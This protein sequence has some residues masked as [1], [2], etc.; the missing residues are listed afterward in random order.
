MAWGSLLRNTAVAA[1]RHALLNWAA[2]LAFYFLFAFFPTVLLV[3]ALLSALH[4]PG[5]THQLLPEFERHLPREAAALVNQ[6]LQR[7]LQEH[8]PGLVS[9]GIVLLLYASSQGF[10]GLMAALNI[11]YDVPETRPYWKQMMISYGLAFSAGLLVV[12]ALGLVLLGR[13]ILGSFAVQSHVG[14]V[15]EM[16]SPVIRWT[17]TLIFLAIAVRLLYRYAPNAKSDARG[18]PLAVATA[19]G[20]WVVASALLGFYI[21]RFSNYAAVYG[22][23]GAVIALMLWFYVLAL[24]LLLGA[25]LHN[26][27]LRQRGLRRE[28]RDAAPASGAARTRL[29]GS[30]SLPGE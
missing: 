4:L 10:A 20:L 25:E 2:A 13:H 8:V 5:L 27:W 21:N 24:A 19:L 11:A 30:K 26:E 14:L 22:S 15:L 1:T 3:A 17:V 28:P 12:L 9:F 23:L 16:A 6:Q 29:S 18:M 7:L